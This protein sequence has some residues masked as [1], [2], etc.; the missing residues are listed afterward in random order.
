MA[1]YE[2]TK[3]DF[4]GSNL[5]DIQGVNTGLIIPWSSTSIPSGFLECDGSAVS[6]S[7]YSAL[8]AVIGT[9]YG[10]G[11]GST[12]FNL[13]DLEDKC[14]KGK[15]TNTNLGTSTSSNTATCTGNL[16][17]SLDNTALPVNLIGPHSHNSGQRGPSQPGLSG[18]TGASNSATLSAGGGGSHNHNIISSFTGDSV[19]VQ[20]P[21]LVTQYIIKT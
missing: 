20:Q 19:S 10:S 4:D 14:V 18:G 21:V 17:G 15:S 2:A 11:D 3:Y 9:T 13:P 6:R 8:F 1:N 7:T 5:T 12:T 16:G